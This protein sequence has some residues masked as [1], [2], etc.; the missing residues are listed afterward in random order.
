MIASVET[1]GLRRNYLSRAAAFDGFE[2]LCHELRLDYGA[3]LRQAGLDSQA[4]LDPD[5]MVPYR[6]FLQVLDA[7]ARA[8]RLPHFGLLLA[9]KQA[10]SMLGPLGFLIAEAPVLSVAIDQLGAYIH[11][12]NQALALKL[13]TANGLACWSYETLVTDPV[14][15]PYED[16]HILM[17]GV[18]F[19]RELLGRHWNPEHVS[20]QHAAPRDVGPYRRK[21]CCPVQFGAER[22]EVVVD[23]RVLDQPLPGHDTRLHA[24]LDGYIKHLDATRSP[25]LEKQVQLILLQAMKQGSCSLTHTAAALAMTPRSLQRRLADAGT[26]FQ[27]ELDTMRNNVARRYLSET[28]MPLTAISTLLGYSDLAAFSRAFKRIN[29]V[30]PQNWR[31]QDR[32]WGEIATPPSSVRI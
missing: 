20:I 31:V 29:G 10:L 2:A 27:A 24:I 1:A 32:S 5:A 12:H 19:I 25:Q 6:A 30:A 28:K 17:V 26:S 15:M 7:A 14:G 13:D 3:L 23:A 22:N 4:L 18:N 11:L 8:S 9:D 16:D 21:F